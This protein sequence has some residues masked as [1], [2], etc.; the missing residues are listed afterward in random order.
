M[1]PMMIYKTIN[2][3]HVTRSIWNNY[4]GPT[5]LVQWRTKEAVG[6]TRPGRHF[7]WGR[8]CLKEGGKKVKVRVNDVKIQIHGQRLKKGRQIF[9]WG[10]AHRISKET[11]QF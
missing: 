9:F 2:N 11:E 6:L 7:Q 4:L 10:D 1:E 5:I 3:C 8:H